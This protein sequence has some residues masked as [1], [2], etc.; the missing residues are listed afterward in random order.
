M[1]VTNKS[2]NFIVQS[3]SDAMTLLLFLVTL[4]SLLR[5]DNIQYV[6]G[7]TFFI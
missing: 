1:K 5:I 3:I 6:V 7:I 4:A 2:Y